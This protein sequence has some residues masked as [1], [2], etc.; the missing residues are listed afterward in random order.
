MRDEEDKTHPAHTLYTPAI[1]FGNIDA[2]VCGGTSVRSKHVAFQ[3]YIVS[4]LVET[5]HHLLVTRVHLY[6]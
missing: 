4:S 2:R 5:H 3:S 1:I 6:R